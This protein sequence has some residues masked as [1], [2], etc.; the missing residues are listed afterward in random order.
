MRYPC[1]P[2]PC[3]PEKKMELHK[4]GEVAWPSGGG[5]KD[6]TE[7][8]EGILVAETTKTDQK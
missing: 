7:E 1:P 6:E 8:G 2:C 3:P 5:G 4:K